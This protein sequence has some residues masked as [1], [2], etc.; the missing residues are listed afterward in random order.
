MPAAGSG[1]AKA[2]S[3]FEDLRLFQVDFFPF[4]PDIGAA[5]GAFI[6]LRLFGLILFLATW[7]RN[8]DLLAHDLSS[9]ANARN[10]ITP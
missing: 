9:S 6:K 1:M 4:G 10:G 3:G 7:T 8:L 2:E 5:F